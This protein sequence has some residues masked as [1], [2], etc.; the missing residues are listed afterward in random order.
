MAGYLKKTK[1]DGTNSHMNMW[2]TTVEN[3]KKINKQYK[4][5]K[6]FDNG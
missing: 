4:K 3:K 5:P 2:T 6:V 1:K